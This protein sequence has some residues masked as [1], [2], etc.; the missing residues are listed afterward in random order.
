M[1][2]YTFGLIAF[3]LLTIA[4]ICLIISLLSSARRPNHSTYGIRPPSGSASPRDVEH[5]LSQLRQNPNEVGHYDIRSYSDW[6]TNQDTIERDKLW[7]IQ[8]IY[9]FGHEREHWEVWVKGEKYATTY[10]LQEANDRMT[11]A[12]KKYRQK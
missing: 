7:A 12:E 10:S 8:H 6:N 5:I 2:F 4:I 11:E 1:T 9:Q 3:P